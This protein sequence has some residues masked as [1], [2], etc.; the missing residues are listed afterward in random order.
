M[1]IKAKNIFSVLFSL[2]KFFL[3]KIFNWHK[4]YF[5]PI[6]RFSPNTQ[7]GFIGGGS[8]ILGKAVRAHSNVKL[9]AINEGVIEIG[10]NVS[11]N[12]GCMIMAMKKISIGKGVEF[13]PNVL[14]YDHDH[15][16]RTEGGLKGNKYKKGEVLIGENSWIG[17]NSVVLRGAK[18]GRN[19]VVAAGSIVNQEIPDDS[20]FVQKREPVI[21][22]IN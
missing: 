18:I 19:C 9:R 5:H 6:E 13:G 22:S 7:V 17:A 8:I 11:I 1:I 12:Y 10:E 15:D 4:F 21:S 16:F 20:V 14:V 3:L 2:I